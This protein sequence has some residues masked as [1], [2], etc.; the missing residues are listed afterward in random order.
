VAAKVPIDAVIG[1]ATNRY[2]HIHRASLRGLGLS[3]RAITARCAA[4]KLVRE[5]KEVYSVGHS[6]RS[7]TAIADAAVMACGPRAALS[8]DSAAA[9]WGLRQWP[10]VPEISSALKH[11]R[12]GIRSHL[13]TTLSRG[14][15]TTRHGIRVTTLART[16]ADIA[17]RLTDEQ[18][19]RV[20]HEARRN[21]HLAG[22]P[23]RRLLNACP[24]AAELIDPTQPP[25]ESAL[26]DAFRLFLKRRDL[27][28]PEFQVDFHGHRVDAIYRDHNLI[29]ELDGRQ[30]H[31]QWHRIEQDHVRDALAIEHRHDTLRITWRRVHEEA[32]EL[33]RQ[34]RAILAARDPR[35]RR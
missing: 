8:H 32:D 5:H 34:L 30:D 16:V 18:L 17:P 15:I 10:P 27:P 4:G 31:G 20:I 11:C 1:Q 28:E 14:D 22:R 12:P 35:A 13:T 6:Q 26:D 25:S 9:L 24:R 2:G 7:L 23:L 29:I 3:Q 19:T 33:E 21:R